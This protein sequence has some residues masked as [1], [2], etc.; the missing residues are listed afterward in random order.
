MP[1]PSCTVPDRLSQR[2]GLSSTRKISF[3]TS[4]AFG[5]FRILKFTPQGQDNQEQISFP[6]SAC[7]QTLRT[8]LPVLNPFTVAK[9]LAFT[10]QRSASLC[11]AFFTQPHSFLWGLCCVKN[12]ESRTCC[13]FHARPL[14]HE[15]VFQVGAMRDVNT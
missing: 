13:D 7:S 4:M 5:A 1:R 11:N 6:C 10:T 8:E 15:R 3:P 9:L 2:H 14:S 12:A